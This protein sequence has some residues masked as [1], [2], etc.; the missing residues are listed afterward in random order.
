MVR[1]TFAR[2]MQDAKLELKLFV[3]VVVVVVGVVVVVV[4]VV[5]EDGA[6]ERREEKRKGKERKRKKGKEKNRKGTAPYASGSL[7][8]GVKNSVCHQ[9][10][11]HSIKSTFLDSSPGGVY[12]R[13]P[14]H[15]SLA[16]I[17]CQG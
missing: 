13:S 16:M 8:G 2:S 12:I 1:A 5:G 11:I 6:E 4:V 3:V 15:F 17:C 7:A 9:R 14:R 10:T